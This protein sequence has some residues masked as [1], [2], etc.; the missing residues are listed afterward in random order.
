[1]FLLFLFL[2]FILVLTAVVIVNESI[3]KKNSTKLTGE[4]KNTELTSV[5][6]SLCQRYLTKLI[7]AKQEKVQVGY[8]A[9][10][11]VQGVV[12]MITASVKLLF[13]ETTL[14]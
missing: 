1:M 5:K 6:E 7:S 12:F 11:V 4:L 13:I 3:E 2:A 10:F 9:V 8:R 14:L